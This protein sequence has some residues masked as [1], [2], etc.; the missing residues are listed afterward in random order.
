M[1]EHDT[2]NLT[3]KSHS[4]IDANPKSTVVV[5]H[6]LWLLTKFIIWRALASDENS[7]P[8]MYVLF[9]VSL[10]QNCRREKKELSSPKRSKK[11]KDRSANIEDKSIIFDWAYRRK[12][13]SVSVVKN[14]SSFSGLKIWTLFS[15]E[16]KKTQSVLLFYALVALKVACKMKY[17]ALHGNSFSSW[18]IELIMYSKDRGLTASSLT[19]EV[20]LF[21]GDT[22]W[23]NTDNRRLISSTKWNLCFTKVWD[24]SRYSTFVD[25]CK[26]LREKRSDSHASG[27]EILDENNPF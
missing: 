25:V 23:W 14:A 18:F 11:D 12:I 26:F 16:A 24:L 10:E 13:N 1:T 27:T 20:T 2:G 15:C 17:N 21:S 7:N 9:F 8:F 6:V 22:D 5:F 19:L 3:R 4:E